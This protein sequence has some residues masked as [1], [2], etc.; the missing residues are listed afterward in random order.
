MA[1]VGHVIVDA[2]Q[3]VGNYFICGTLDKRCT[4][5]INATLNFNFVIDWNGLGILHYRGLH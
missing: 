2:N 1:M 5:N 3:P 4:P